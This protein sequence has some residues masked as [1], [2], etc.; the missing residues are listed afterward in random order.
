MKERG[1]EAVRE[2]ESLPRMRAASIILLRTR[3][4]FHATIHKIRDRRAYI[5]RVREI[6]ETKKKK[7]EEVRN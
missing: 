7:E 5:I 6:K 2:V 3:C 4:P 1:R